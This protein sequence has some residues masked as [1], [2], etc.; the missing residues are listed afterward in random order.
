VSYRENLEAVR[1]DCN[2]LDGIRVHIEM[3]TLFY[4]MNKIVPDGVL[5]HPF[6]HAEFLQNERPAATKIPNLVTHTNQDTREKS[7]LQKS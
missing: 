4:P 2:V 3:R 5:E 6:M 7:Q 1:G